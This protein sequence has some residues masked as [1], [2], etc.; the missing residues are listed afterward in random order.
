MTVVY[1]TIK[2]HTNTN[3]STTTSTHQED[4]TTIFDRLGSFQI[5]ADNYNY[6]LNYNYNTTTFNMGFDKVSTSST[7]N[8]TNTK[9]NSTSNSS[10][11]NSSSNSLFGSFF[12]NNSS[13]NSSNNGSNSTNQGKDYRSMNLWMPQGMWPLCH[14]CDPFVTVVTTL[15]LICHRLSCHTS[16]VTLCRILQWDNDGDCSDLRDWLKSLCGPRKSLC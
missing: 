11:K 14:K 5:T 10:Q 15:W 16:S 6:N 13:N 7:T 3:N 2:P 8:T 9:T 4:T 1:N 12:Y